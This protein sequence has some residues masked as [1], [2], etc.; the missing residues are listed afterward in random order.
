MTY[1]IEACS[2]CPLPLP[3]A[4]SPAIFVSPPR[5]LHDS[6]NIY[7]W[8]RWRVPPT[9]QSAPAARQAAR[10]IA[11]LSSESS[12]EGGSRTA[13]ATSRTY[14]EGG[15]IAGART[16]RGSCAPPHGPVALPTCKCPPPPPKG[17]HQA[18]NAG[19]GLRS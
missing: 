11:V 6:I 1:C 12:F 4:A 9:A 19:S 3:P 5:V 16:Q 17:A 2:M 7:M 8:P 15:R 14:T 18:L 13:P 10:A